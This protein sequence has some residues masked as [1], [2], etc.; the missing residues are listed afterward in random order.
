MRA[1]LQTAT[2][3]GNARTGL[4]AG[5]AAQATAMAVVSA[6]ALSQEGE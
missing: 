3:T 1:L 6:R 4:P 5:K 2:H